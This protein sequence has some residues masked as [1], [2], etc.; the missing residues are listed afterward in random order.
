[1]MKL[2]PQGFRNSLPQLLSFFRLGEG[3]YSYFLFFQD[4]LPLKAVKD[5]HDLG[6]LGPG[7]GLNPIDGKLAFK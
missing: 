5:F 3:K 6:G 7:K 4:P 2:L 1:M